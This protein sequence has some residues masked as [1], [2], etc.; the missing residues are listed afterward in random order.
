MIYRV[1]LV[2]AALVGLS[3]CVS[4]PTGG[5]SSY[6]EHYDAA[7]C[8]SGYHA[9]DLQ[10]HLPSDAGEVLALTQ[11]SEANGQLA[12]QCR[13][14]AGDVNNHSPGYPIYTGEVDTGNRGICVSART[15]G[16]GHI[17]SCAS[18][19]QVARAVDAPLGTTRSVLRLTNWRPY[20]GS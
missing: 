5:S 15:T 1:F 3:G 11:F 9:F 16:R 4:T 19:A 6:P 2:A 8:Y 20:P 10:V 7:S 13:L 17:L 12:T 14:I 18:R